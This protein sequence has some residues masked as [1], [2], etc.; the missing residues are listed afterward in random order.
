MVPRK[1]PNLYQDLFRGVK[2]FELISPRIKKTIDIYIDQN[3]ISSFFNKGHKETNIKKIKKTIPKL[4]FDTG[5]FFSFN[6]II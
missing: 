1:I 3:L 4:L 2:N 5:K 6:F